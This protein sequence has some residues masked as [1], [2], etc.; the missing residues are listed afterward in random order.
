MQKRRDK[1]LSSWADLTSCE[2]WGDRS[3]RLHDLGMRKLAL[4]LIGESLP[5]ILG[6]AGPTP[7]PYHRCGRVSSHP[8]L[9]RLVPVGTPYHLPRLW[10][11]GTG[12]RLVR[13]NHSHRISTAGEWWGSSVDGVPK[14]LYLTNNTLQ[15]DI[16]NK[17]VGI[18]GCT[19][20]YTAASSADKM[21]EELMLRQERWR[22][23][24]T[25]LLV[26]L[27]FALF[28]C[29]I[30]I[31]CIFIYFYFYLNFIISILV[32]LWGYI[33]RVKGRYGGTWKWVKLGR[34]I[35][36]S[37]KKKISE[38]LCCFKKSYLHIAGPDQLP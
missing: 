19:A 4:L 11:A 38:K 5:H 13:Q 1:K 2:P 16:C 6:K 26:C 37:P 10:P 29:L 27:V 25:F 8:H 23:E 12:K 32:L 9:R 33:I 36:N 35:W 15:N 14:A 18:K 22:S 31:I 28:F 24:V 34:M 7:H 17:A 3:W 21:K 20:W 30:N